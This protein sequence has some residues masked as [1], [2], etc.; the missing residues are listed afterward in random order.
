MSSRLRF[1]DAI[2]AG[3][4]EYAFMPSMVSGSSFTCSA[5]AASG[6]D[7]CRKLSEGTVE[8]II[9]AEL[10]AAASVASLPLWPEEFPARPGLLHL[11]LRETDNRFECLET[12]ADHQCG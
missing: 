7:C 11:L 6:S 2:T 5:S 8:N 12:S 4:C 1:S 9:I 10:S 3:V